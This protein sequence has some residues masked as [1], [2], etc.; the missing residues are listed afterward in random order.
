MVMGGTMPP[1]IDPR[2]AL[3]AIGELPD[4]EIDLA[5]AALQLARVDAPGADW[6]AARTHLS[7]LAR[8]A[9]RLSIDVGADDLAA[10]ATAL[11]GLLAGRFGYQG[12]AE[13]YDDLA[14]ANLIR[15]VE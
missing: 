9:V 11:A 4:T 14:N 6:G 3:D 1:M 12:D 15:V 5:D 10:Q 13:T 2:T 8:A 7:D